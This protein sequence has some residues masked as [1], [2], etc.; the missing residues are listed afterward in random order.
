MRPLRD[1]TIGAKLEAISVVVA[2]TILALTAAL[3]SG[4]H[5]N[6]VRNAMVDEVNLVAATL[7]YHSRSPTRVRRRAGGGRDDAFGDARSPNSIG[8]RPRCASGNVLAA[9]GRDE[10]D[11]RRP[12]ATHAGNVLRGGRVDRGGS[13]RTRLRRDRPRR[14]ANRPEPAR[15]IP[16]PV[17]HRVGTGAGRGRVRRLRSVC[18]ATASGVGADRCARELCARARD[19]PRL[20]EA[21]P[22]TGDGTRS[23]T[24]SMPSTRSCTRSTCAS[25]PRSA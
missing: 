6:Q 10:S 19:R 2:G 18:R 25:A 15:R 16:A 4:W 22:A 17:G 5:Y 8:D 13:G 14:G 20:V 23:A 11:T 24:S 1:W 21:R 12:A 3:L 7:A 9:Y